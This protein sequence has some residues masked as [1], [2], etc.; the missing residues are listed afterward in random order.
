MPTSKR[1]RYALVGTGNRGTT[2]WGRDLLE[3][4]NDAVELVAICDLNPLRADRARNYMGASAPIYTDF[5]AL[6]QAERPEL[7]IVCT[8]DS[9]HDD[10]I[11]K[12]LE[13]G[14]DVISEKPMTTTVDKIKRI[15][16]AERRTGKRVD[17]SFNYRF[18][19]TAAR[20]KELLNSGVIGE[21][22]SVDF[23]WYLD[24]S[25][26]AD[27]FRRWHA[28]SEYSGSLFV[29]KATHHF[30]LL[31]WYLDS[32]PETVSAFAELKHYGRNGPFRGERCLTCPH[33]DDC[34]YFFDISKD[35]FLERL[36]EEPSTV[37]GYVRDACVFREDIDIPD[38]MVA[39]IRYRN[40]IE[41]SYSLNT[42][43]PIEGHHIAF[44]GHKGRIEL[45]QYE[46][47]AWTTPPADEIVV[48][49]NFDGVERI[50]VPHS[51]GGHYGGDDRLR[52]ML[53]SPAPND[54]LKQRAGSRAGAMSVLCGI[55]A[56]LSS[57]TG[58]PV[59]IADLWGKDS[60]GLLVWQ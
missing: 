51:S 22:T 59:S 44:N 58:S 27:Y 17:I 28:F 39:S 26:G 57:R 34:D 53:F 52:N 37:D 19:P 5:D 7:V 8:R 33:K 25:H 20:I 29:H 12:A 23:H 35:P 13:A 10:I 11:V 4:W 18:A 50:W 42:Y 40:G 56:F 24:T 2:M 31:N 49:R 54:E 30:D 38:T 60:S 41:V 36:Y 45:R 6:L 32:D 55:A 1:T 16:E 3:R 43:M 47:Q 48:M 15:L 14:A 21:V 9:T 46:A